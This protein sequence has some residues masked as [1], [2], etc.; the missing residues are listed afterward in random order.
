M[1]RGALLIHMPRGMAPTV[2]AE[3]TGTLST[4]PPPFPG[5]PPAQF[6]QTPNGSCKCPSSPPSPVIVKDEVKIDTVVV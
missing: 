4:P 5:T 2:S 1:E 3:S 6:S